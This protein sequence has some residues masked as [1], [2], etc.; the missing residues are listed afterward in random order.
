MRTTGSP[1]TPGGRSTQ[2]S[3]RR[4]T[5]VGV[6]VVALIVAVSAAFTVIRESEAPDLRTCN[7]SEELCAYRLDEVSL[8][9]SHNSMNAADDGFAHPSQ[10]SCIEAL[11]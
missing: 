4:R 6:G 8:A 3:Q 1:T 2:L 5:L 10:W 7:G 11:L 9:T